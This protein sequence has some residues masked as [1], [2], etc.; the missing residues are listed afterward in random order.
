MTDKEPKNEK[1]KI[2]PKT[3]SGLGG[4]KHETQTSLKTNPKIVSIY[5][6]NS[7]D[8]EVRD[9]KTH[10]G[11]NSTIF[12]INDI[13][14]DDKRNSKDIIDVTMSIFNHVSK[15]VRKYGTINELWIEGHGSTLTMGNNQNKDFDIMKFINL[16]D[17][18]SSL[19]E[20]FPKISNRIIFDGCDTFKK[21]TPPE[22]EKLR[23]FADKYDIEIVGTTSPTAS[24]NHSRFKYLGIF[25]E[26]VT[27]CLKPFFG[28]RYI[29]FTPEG[30]VLRDK[31][32]NNTSVGSLFED[33]SWIDYH[34]N[35]TQK[36]GEKAQKEQIKRDAE[37]K[38]FWLSKGKRGT[39]ISKGD[40]F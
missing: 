1:P 32:D 37:I 17:K 6:F 34:L 40:N 5:L 23:N 9:E 30:E 2:D 38:E 21:L 24:V 25:E 4:V 35:H 8:A 11:E 18:F 13:L 39:S 19:F 15:H 36:E 3:L 29:K 10:S 12:K 14:P 28:G 26:I 20:N 16:T 22:I 27:D 33:R 31:L 7:I